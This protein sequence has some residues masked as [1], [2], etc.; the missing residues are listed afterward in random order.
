MDIDLYHYLIGRADQSVAEDALKTRCSHQIL[1][2]TKIFMAYDLNEVRKKNP[3]LA[4]YMYH[5]IEFM[6][7]IATAF[8]R[9]NRSEEAECMVRDMWE[10][11][12]EFDAKLARRVRYAS[13]AAFV[14][15]PGKVGRGLGLAGYR[16][17]HKFVAFN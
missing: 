13:I 4:R 6:M 16:L 10:E 1:V 2:S 5:E 14:N 17:C 9:L 3:K 12:S 15:L 8:T 7:A 11:V